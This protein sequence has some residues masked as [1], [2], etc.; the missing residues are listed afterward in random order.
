MKTLIGDYLKDISVVQEGKEDQ[1]LTEETT[2]N[3][4]VLFELLHYVQH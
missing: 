1:E 2:Y 3:L 4:D